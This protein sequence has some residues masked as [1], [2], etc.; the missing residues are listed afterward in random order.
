MTLFIL[1]LKSHSSDRCFSS[2]GLSKTLVL[3]NDGALLGLWRLFKCREGVAVFL[4]TLK[5][6]S[7]KRFS[8]SARYFSSLDLFKITDQFL[9]ERSLIC[10]TFGYNEEPAVSLKSC[11]VCSH[12][13]FSVSKS[14]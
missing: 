4:K 9:M 3:R 2:L 7:Y 12:E 1:S 13:R 10:E 8:V 11:S 5:R 14:H 6:N